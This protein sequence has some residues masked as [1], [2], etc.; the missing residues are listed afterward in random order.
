MKK[1]IRVKSSVF[2]TLLRARDTVYCIVDIQYNCFF[3]NN[4]HRYR[5]KE[6]SS[7]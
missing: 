7:V 2:N 1:Y 6:I 4:K 5:T 3:V